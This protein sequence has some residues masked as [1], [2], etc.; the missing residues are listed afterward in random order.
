M[1]RIDSDPRFD[2]VLW[3]HDE[4]I[5]EAPIGTMEVPAFEK[6]VSEVSS[7]ASTMPVEAEGW[8]GPR[9]RK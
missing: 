6:L 7:W 3:I 5:A 2:L 1:L 9:L 4:V 8:R